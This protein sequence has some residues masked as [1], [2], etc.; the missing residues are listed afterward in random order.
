MRKLITAV[1]IISLVLVITHTALAIT[2]DIKA[3]GSDMPI[4]IQQPD[5]L[6]V[7]VS[8]DPESSPGMDCDWWVAASTPFGW[9]YFDASTM[10]W[11]YA[12]SSHTALSPTYKGPLI[13]LST[14]EVLNMPDLPAGTY[15]FYFAVDTN[16]N[17]V[18]G[19]NELFFDSV[20]VNINP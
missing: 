8:L 1:G 14:F 4:D 5:S 15:T 11:D 16:M 7:I 2:P 3:N 9:Y 20:V 13:D 18:L 19:F 10:S 6:S 17:S 12:G